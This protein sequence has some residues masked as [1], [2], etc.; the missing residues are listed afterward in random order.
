M[1]ENTETIKNGLPL[2][3]A[4][5][6]PMET[7]FDEQHEK[8]LY[9]KLY[10]EVED[11]GVGMQA[12]D[13]N[14]LF[15]LFGKLQDNQKLNKN[16][17]GLGLNICKRIIQSMQGNVIVESQPGK[18]TIFKMFMVVGKRNPNASGA[19]LTQ[20]ILQQ[21]NF[22]GGGG[23]FASVNYLKNIN[24]SLF[25][26]QKNLIHKRCDFNSS[27][28]LLHSIGNKYLKH[29]DRSMLNFTPG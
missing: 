22:S 1:L 26:L 11:S 2:I 8:I 3:S 17:T 16:G 14:K 12:K 4:F 19:N 28:S 27:I 25:E 29:A 13:L 9:R 24:Q 23:N 15:K 18:G 5:A 20:T 10:I 6:K 7:D 21:R